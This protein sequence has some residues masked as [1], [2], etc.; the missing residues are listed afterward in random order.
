LF[1]AGKPE[2][3][4]LEMTGVTGVIMMAGRNAGIKRRED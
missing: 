1:N 3:E 2:D 4:K